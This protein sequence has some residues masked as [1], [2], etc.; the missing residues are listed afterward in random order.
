MKTESYQTINFNSKKD[1]LEFLTSLYGSS[2]NF[3]L[4]LKEYEKAYD[5]CCTSKHIKF[6]PI[7]FYN[8]GQMIAHV[9]LVVDDRLGK[10]EAFFGF[11]EIVDDVTVFEV[12]WRK[13]I[14]LAKVHKLQILKG[15]VNGSIWHQYRCIKEDSPEPY[16]KTEPMTPLYYYD[17]LTYVNPTN[18]VTY[19]SGIRDSYRT[20]LELLKKQKNTILRT[21]SDGNFKIGVTKEISPEILFSIA[22]LSAVVFNERS[23]GYTNLDAAE[24]SNLYDLSKINEHIYKLFLLYQNDV[25]VGYCST[26]KEGQDLVCK[27]ICIAPEFQGKGLGNALALKVHEEAEIDGIE[28]IMYVLVKDGNQVHNYPMED[29]RVFRKYSVFEYKLTV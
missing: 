20:I 22:K 7:A 28:K 12:V 13:L 15:P 24:F 14:E 27:T 23:W 3:N 10:G 21:L 19:S 17:F 2:A 6:F 26:M 25:L 18:E 11:F 16:F 8:D 29:V 9:A 5:F 1:L 4:F